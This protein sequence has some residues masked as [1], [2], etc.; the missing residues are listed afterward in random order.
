MEDFSQCPHCGSA[1]G[2]LRIYKCLDPRGRGLQLSRLLE[3]Q[4][5]RVLGYS[6]SVSR[7]R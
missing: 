3:Q 4:R 6:R 1:D 5:G 7:L 2:S